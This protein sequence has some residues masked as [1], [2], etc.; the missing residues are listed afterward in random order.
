MHKANISYANLLL[1][2]FPISLIL[3]SAVVNL[4]LILSSLYV[5]NY[6]LK[7]QII[8]YKFFWFKVFICFLFF[9]I[10][11]SFLSNEVFPA[12]KSALS[13]FRFILFSLFISL[14]DLNKIFKLFINLLLL[15]IL[16]VCIDVN[17]QFIFGYDIFGYPAEG[18]QGNDYKPLAHWQNENIKIGRLSGPFESELIPG[19]F[20]SC[21]SP[22]LIF[23][24]LN[25]IKFRSLKKKFIKLFL[26]F[27]LFQSV[28]I[29]GERLALILILVTILISL[30]VIFNIKK[31]LIFLFFLFSILTFNLSENNF[32]KKRWIDAYNIAKDIK[33]SSYGRIYSSAFMVWQNHKIFGSGLK[34]YKTECQKL[35]DPNPYIEPKKRKT[36]KKSYSV[37]PFCSP[38]HPHNNY[39]EL[40]AET[41]L[42][43]FITFYMFY[44]SLIVYL[45]KNY[46]RKTRDNFIILHL[47]VFFI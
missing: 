27:F 42:I 29:T 2:F 13:Q 30:L 18:Y 12:L 37:H 43:G 47:E 23:Y 25:K 11:T 26:V 34:N 22:P 38:T 6:S 19:A 28:L 5:I 36:V 7:S 15:L 20:I 39:L 32:L 33:G 8:F 4:T 14:I 35:D 45:F 1:L 46:C 16:F 21:L 24:Y 40:L 31:N 41:G 17:I 44:F 10:I 3:G 9:V